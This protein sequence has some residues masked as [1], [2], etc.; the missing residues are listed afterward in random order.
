MHVGLAGAA[1]VQPG[2]G[3]AAGRGAVRAVVR[4]GTAIR[5]RLVGFLLRAVPVVRARRAAAVGAIDAIAGL[6]STESAGIRGRAGISGPWS[7]AA[8]LSVPLSV[9]VVLQL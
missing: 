8:S 3:V 7:L 4:G 5:R 6:C 2:K 1:A 9:P